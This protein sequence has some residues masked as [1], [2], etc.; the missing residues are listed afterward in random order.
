[1]NMLKHGFSNVIGMNGTN[2]PKTV[3]DLSRKK[4]VTLFAG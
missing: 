2:I 1:M 4:I 3:I